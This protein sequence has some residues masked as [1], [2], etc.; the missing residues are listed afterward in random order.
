MDNEEGYQTKEGSED[1]DETPVKVREML[2]DVP[3]YVAPDL[4]VPPDYRIGPD[5]IYKVTST[6]AGEREK[7]IAHYPILLAYKLRGRTGREVLGV[8]WCSYTWRKR[9]LERVEVARPRDLMDLVN[10]GF[11]INST[12]A[13]DVVRYLAAFEAANRE[14]LLFNPYRPAQVVEVGR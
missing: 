8:A 9:E 11:P 14:A 1:M 12:N 5:G 6:K 3:E 2:P 13:S 7:L 10:I 4:L